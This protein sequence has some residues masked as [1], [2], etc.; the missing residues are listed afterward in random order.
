MQ[1]AEA[2]YTVPFLHH[3][4]ME[5]MNGTAH[6]VDGR[7]ELWLPTQSQASTRARVVKELG[8]AEE[9]VTLHT[10]LAGVPV[11][12][13]RS[14]AASQNCFAYEGF[15]DEL[16]ARARLDPLV[17]RRRLLAGQPRHLRVRSLA[18]AREGYTLR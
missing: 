6:V 1:P 7:A 9:Q 12:Y 17:Y 15:I 13:W 4:T 16:A 2:V 11:G 14:V 8:L 5:P 10:T 3:A 18:L